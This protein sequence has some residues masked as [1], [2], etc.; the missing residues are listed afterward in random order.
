MEVKDSA[1]YEAKMLLYC[2]VY[3]VLDLNEG[4]KQEG[5]R[6]RIELK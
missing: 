3:N 1:K 5:D 2:T 4:V 6:C